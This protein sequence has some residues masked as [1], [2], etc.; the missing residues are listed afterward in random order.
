MKG[1]RRVT[2]FPGYDVWYA[3]WRRT[4][5]P[6]TAALKAFWEAATVEH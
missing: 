3:E 1:K 4:V 6:D 2:A 5:V